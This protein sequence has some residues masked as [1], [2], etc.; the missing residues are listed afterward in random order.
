MSLDHIGSVGFLEPCIHNRKYIISNKHRCGR[1]KFVVLFAV[2]YA[3]S[4]MTKRESSIS[5]YLNLIH[6]LSTNRIIDQMK[7]S[8]TSQF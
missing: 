6:L 4:C 1:R 2:T 3:L 7:T 8:K 5:I